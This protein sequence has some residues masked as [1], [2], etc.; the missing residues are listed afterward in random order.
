MKIPKLCNNKS[1]KRTF[2][3]ENGKRMFRGPWG[4]TE[5][6]AAYKLYIHN[7]TT[8][9]LQAPLERIVRR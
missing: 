8:K 1:R 9:T 4:A 6:E 7:I 2:V 5:T 3:M